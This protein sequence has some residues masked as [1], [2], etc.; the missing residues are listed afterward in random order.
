MSEMITTLIMSTCMG[1]I[2]ILGSMYISQLF[3]G[4]LWTKLTIILVCII[5][6]L[7]L[8]LTANLMLSNNN[9]VRV[10]YGESPNYERDYPVFEEDDR[11][12]EV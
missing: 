6:A 5:G 11:E 2:V 12:I 10:K 1:L 8:S 9:R 4:K 7:G 3:T